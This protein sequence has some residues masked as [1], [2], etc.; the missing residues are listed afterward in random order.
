MYAK[1]IIDEIIE[2]RAQHRDT[3]L[4]DK[5]VAEVEQYLGDVITDETSD[6]LATA[7]C[8]DLCIDAANELTH[9]KDEARAAARRACAQLGYPQKGYRH[10]R[11]E[12][13]AEVHAKAPT[14]VISTGIHHQTYDPRRR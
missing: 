4:A 8:W 11:I 10:S 12:Q 14:P 3:S 2:N 13:K 1:D 6:E 9:N 7:E 5:I